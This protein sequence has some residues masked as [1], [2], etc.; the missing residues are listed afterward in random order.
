MDWLQ[1]LGAV[2]MIC[3]FIGLLWA[4]FLTDKEDIPKPLCPVC[5]EVELIEDD[6]M[7]PGCSSFIDSLRYCK[8]H[9]LAYNGLECPKCKYGPMVPRR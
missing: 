1:I 4:M 5:Q 7:C 6:I 3:G 9:G 2:S 8:S